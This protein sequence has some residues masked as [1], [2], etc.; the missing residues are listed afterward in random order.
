M[1]L[2]ILG[3]GLVGGSIARSLHERGEPGQWHV[4]AWSRNRGP[5]EQAVTDGAV[6]VAAATVGEAVRDAEMVVLAAPPLICLDLIDMLAGPLRGSLPEDCTVT[7]VASAKG[8]IVATADA[9]RLPF[10]GGH[11]MAG[12][13]LSSYAAALPDLFVERPWVTVLG[14]YARLCDGERIGELI[15]ACGAIQI[16]MDAHAHDSAVAAISHLP[17]IVSAALVESIAG[18]PDEPER[19]DWGAAEAL[20]ATGWAGMTRLAR[21]EPAMGAGIA[22][23]NAVAIAARLRGLRDVLDR[24]LAELERDGGPNEAALAARFSAARQRLVESDR[25]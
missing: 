24:W 21:G 14:R 15:E 3:F 25:P 16:P 8:R 9:A 11:P 19:E 22:A 4:T 23:T 17:L 18:G 7:D 6:A 2:S 12:R 10:I 20:A 5:V 13:E 1:R